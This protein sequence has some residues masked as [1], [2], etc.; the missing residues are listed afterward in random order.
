K[1]NLK[2]LENEEDEHPKK[3]KFFKILTDKRK[4]R[5]CLTKDLQNLKEIFVALIS[6]NL[7]A[8]T[9]IADILS[10][11]TFISPSST[12][13]TSID[14][15][16]N[17]PLHVA[18]TSGNSRITKLLISANADP[19]TRNCRGE[20]ALMSAISTNASATLHTFPNILS[21]FQHQIAAVDHF[22]RSVFHHL[23][24]ARHD[25]VRFYVDCLGEHL[26][27]FQNVAFAKV[28]VDIID[29]A[30]D[31]ALHLALSIGNE[32]VVS[33]LLDFGA[34]IGLVNGRGVTAAAM[35]RGGGTWD[36]WMN[37]RQLE[38]HGIRNSDSI[39]KP[40]GELVCT[41]GYE[42]ISNSF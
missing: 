2:Y 22:G 33:A 26:I 39:S 35:M 42:D 16:G 37:Y 8:D 17:T 6:N 19:A 12:I 1:Q 14:D 15:F 18:A 41:Q 20:T 7:L 27:D 5:V 13:N 4:R 23:A 10:T 38:D 9:H 40:E 3:S 28:V 11:Y 32:A 29:L 30:G 36:Y 24:V 21:W 34:S 31:T 25:F